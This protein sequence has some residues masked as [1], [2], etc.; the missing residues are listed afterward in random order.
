VEAGTK[1]TKV[2]LLRSIQFPAIIDLYDHCSDKLKAELN[3]G[4]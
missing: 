1:A 3:V 4:K 2:K